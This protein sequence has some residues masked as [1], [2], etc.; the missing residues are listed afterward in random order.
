MEAEETGKWRGI[1]SRRIEIREKKAVRGGTS[2]ESG[3][4]IV[5]RELAT[6]HCEPYRLFY[7]HRKDFL[8]L[9]LGSFPRK[10]DLIWACL[11]FFQDD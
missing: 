1:K 5:E 9:R 6:L 4:A 10:F 11:E 8:S 2:Y 3:I 7:L